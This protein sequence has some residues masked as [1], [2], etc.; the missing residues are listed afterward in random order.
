MDVAMGA[1]ETLSNEWEILAGRLLVAVWK[2]YVQTGIFNFNIRI[3][4]F[5]IAYRSLAN[6]EK[7]LRR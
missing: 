5:L 1:S 7:S 6:S 3:L 4:L 2:R